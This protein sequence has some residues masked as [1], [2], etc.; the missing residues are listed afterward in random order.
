MKVVN[1][2]DW[3][4]YCAAVE[5]EE[6]GKAFVQFLTAWL[7]NAERA[8][9]NDMSLNPTDAIRES[10]WLTQQQIGRVSIEYIGQMLLVII[11]HWSHGPRVARGI[12]VIERQLLE[13]AAARLDQ[14]R[15]EQAER[16][17]QVVQDFLAAADMESADAA[18]G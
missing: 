8:L 12:N 4:E 14:V 11:S 6:W 18:A 10:L 16:R 15:R 7:T 3:Q 1:E 2:Q 5:H 13:E 17:E 9:E